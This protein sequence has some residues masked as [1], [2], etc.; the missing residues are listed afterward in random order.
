MRRKDAF[1]LA[2]AVL[3]LVCTAAPAPAANIGHGCV[4]SAVSSVA[5]FTQQDLGMGFG[6]YFH[7]IDQVP[8][9]S[10]QAHSGEFCTRT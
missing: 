3:L 9:Q 10:I 6:A 2:T 7:S 5:Q 8:G 4:G 1:C